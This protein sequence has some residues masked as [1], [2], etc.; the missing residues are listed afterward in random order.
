MGSFSYEPLGDV[1][2]IRVVYIEPALAASDPI[3]CSLEIVHLDAKPPPCYEALSYVWGSPR[4]TIPISCDGKSLLVTPNL[5]E[6][7]RRIRHFR[8]TRLLWVDAICINQDDPME[9]SVQV[10]AMRDIYAKAANVIIWLGE[11]RH[12][13]SSDI[14]FGKPLTLTL[15][16]KLALMEIAGNWPG[17]MPNLKRNVQELG[18][19]RKSMPGVRWP[20]LNPD[21]SKLCTALMRVRNEALQLVTQTLQAILACEWFC[22][23]WILQ[24]TVVNFPTVMI[25]DDTIL[26]TELANIFKRIGSI[27][28]HSLG[29]DSLELK[30]LKEMDLL[31]RR[32]GEFNTLEQPDSTSSPMT[33]EK[34]FRVKNLTYL[35]GISQ[36]FTCSDPRDKVYAFLGLAEEG[37][38]SEDAL[39]PD[40]TIPV[41]EVYR[42]VAEYILTTTRSLEIWS[43]GTTRMLCGLPTWVPDWSVATDEGRWEPRDEDAIVRYFKEFPFNS[44]DFS[45]SK[46]PLEL[47]I[48]GLRI[49]IISEVGPELKAQC[50]SEAVSFDNDF[51]EVSASWEHVV[52]NTLEDDPYADRIS[53]FLEAITRLDVRSKYTRITFEQ[54]YQVHGSGLFSPISSVEAIPDDTSITSPLGFASSFHQSESSDPWHGPWRDFDRDYRTRFEKPADLLFQITERVK[55]SCYGRSL[56]STLDNELGL[57]PPRA[58]T[59]DL[60]VYFPGGRRPFIIR[61]ICGL[62]GLEQRYELI[63]DCSL[64]GLAFRP[65]RNLPLREFVLR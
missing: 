30:R 47:S 42:R 31:R 33:T 65:S 62:A 10:Q 55:E 15:I 27:R 63:G 20:S 54:W 34:A 38:L 52:S 16:R 49:G 39:R 5:L 45:K 26:W 56:C 1:R 21:L 24:E 12:L 43:V 19:A 28:I 44:I 11:G 60:V 40:Y 23:M 18:W 2:N 51:L 36:L 59:G 9:R 48:M 22:R 46:D 13:P 53:R 25:A 35:L 32:I 57:A 6:A 61:E 3:S 41:T 4:G 29:K 50:A 8:Y 14:S 7:L 37:I 58:M 17:M 64:R